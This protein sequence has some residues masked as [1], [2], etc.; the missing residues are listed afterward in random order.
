MAGQASIAGQSRMAHFNSEAILGT[1]A[2]FQ[3]L[4]SWET[5]KHTSHLLTSDG[6]A[7]P[8]DLTIDAPI[9]TAALNARK[10]VYTDPEYGLMRQSLA[11]AIDAVPFAGLLY[12]KLPSALKA[13][14][15]TEANRTSLFKVI[16][17][18]VIL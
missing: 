12:A 7:P 5:A 10:F 2:S 18:L 15:S 3:D 1:S 9:P 4:F 6:G 14:W 11:D 16:F 13:R 17:G 8:A